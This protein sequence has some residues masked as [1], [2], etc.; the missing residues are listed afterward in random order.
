VG[1]G[2]NIGVA[3]E[4]NRGVPEVNT[5]AHNDRLLKDGGTLVA[6]ERYQSNDFGLFK[7]RHFQAMSSTA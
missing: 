3:S 2:R 1:K 5:K 7:G 6:A 4:A